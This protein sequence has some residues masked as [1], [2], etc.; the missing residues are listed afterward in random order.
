MPDLRALDAYL[1]GLGGANP[2]LR[3]ACA[4][5]VKSILDAAL[6]EIER[7]ASGKA[8][9]EAEAS[10]LQRLYAG[11]KEGAP[12]LFEI[13]V[14]RPDAAAYLEFAMKTA[15]DPER[16]RRIF[17][18]AQGAGCVKCHRVAREGGEVG[19][20]L[21][22]VGGQFGR[23]ELAESVLYPSKVVREGY[24][25]VTVR[26]RDGRVLSGSVRA[27]SA[28]EFA[29]LDAEGKSHRLLKAEMEARKDSYVSLMPEGLERGLSP[30]G[31]ADLVA[32][33][34]S[35]KGSSK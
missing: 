3:D 12:R 33:L 6:A 27:E 26:M 7:R 17:F 19:P 28:E 11:R 9:S 2:S 8:L 13:A 10:E 18:D 35:L 1:F 16:G 15:G 14:K 32:Y 25:Q 30:D 34:E 23:R 4:K 24:G 29:L 21:S 5:A 20:D 22:G 31:F